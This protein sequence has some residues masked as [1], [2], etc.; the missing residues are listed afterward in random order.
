MDMAL[1]FACSAA[2]TVQLQVD[3]ATVN[4][5]AELTLMVNTDEQNLPVACISLVSFYLKNLF[6]V[7]FLTADATSHA[8]P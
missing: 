6:F 7:F 3:G 8:L 5:V 1:N 4:A 2:P